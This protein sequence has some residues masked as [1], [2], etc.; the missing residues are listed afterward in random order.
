MLVNE[1]MRVCLQC[2]LPKSEKTPEA[3]R[4]DKK[5]IKEFQVNLVV[6]QNMEIAGEK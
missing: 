2:Q 6:H 4:Q 1:L 3:Q 5:C